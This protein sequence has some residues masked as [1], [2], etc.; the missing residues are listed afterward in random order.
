MPAPVAFSYTGRDTTGK[1]V[2]G[3]IDG[4]TPGQVATRLNAQGI[5]PVSI[6]PAAP[7]T[8]LARSVSL[9]GFSR[10]V[11]LKDL[12]ILSR[13]FATMISAGLSLLRALRILTEQTESKPLAAVL[14]LV[15]DDVEAGQSISEAL[16]KHPLAF[17][18]I[19]V[20]MVRAGETGGF[21]DRALNSIA[22]NFE[23]E[24]KLRGTI[25]SAM[26]YPVIVLAMSLAA[27]M[28]MLIF[29][30]PI[31]QDMFAGLGG[32]LPLP[33]Q[34]LVTMSQSMIYVVPIGLVV[35]VAFALW[36][37][38]NKHTDRVRQ[39]LDPLRLKLPVFGP[40]QKKISVARF[41]RNFANML[42]AGVPILQAL[43][44]VGETSGNWAIEHALTEVAEGV[45]R[46]QSV[47]E[48]LQEHSIFPAMVTQ[49]IAVGEDA[50]TL[51]LMLDKIADFYDQ[52]VHAATEQLTAMIEPLLIAFL[53]VVIGG[54]VI[55]LYLPIFSI[56]SMIK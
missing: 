16:A 25:K 31:F 2:K 18:P 8:G 28:I 4:V 47:S 5:A 9:P 11:R 50:G 34:L 49:M 24:V 22:E 36:W 13:Q 40:L 1:N 27:V 37:R 51:Q 54:M 14:A 12:A 3:R 42:G 20:N 15:R 6:A 56:A 7:A 38:K 33:T 30:V 41:S 10:G 19:M 43:K 21:L 48:P 55:A 17:P 44:I 29:I 32:A 35:G 45:R 53:G 39:T 26:T 23:K 52:E 46:G